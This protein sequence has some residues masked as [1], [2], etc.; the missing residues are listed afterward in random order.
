MRQLRED[1]T[2]VQAGFLAIDPRTSAVLA[3]VGSRD[4][5]QDA[6]DH[7]AQARRQPGSTFKPFVYGAA[8]QRAPGPTTRARTKPWKSSCPAARYGVPAMPSSPRA[9]P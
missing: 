6:F 3:W 9:C 7:V 4:F 5:A 2:R 1:K 8:L